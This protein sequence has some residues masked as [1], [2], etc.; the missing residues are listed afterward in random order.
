M[1]IIDES[2]TEQQLTDLFKLA[3]L[4]RDGK[5]CYEGKLIRIIP[6]NNSHVPNYSMQIS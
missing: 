4:D 6:K 3:D 5:I 1:E 2:I